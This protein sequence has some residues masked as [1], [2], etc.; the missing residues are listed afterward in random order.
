[1]Q[2][3][4]VD[5]RKISRNFEVNRNIILGLG[6]YNMFEE[7][8]N[9]FIKLEE[10]N[11][12]LSFE[13]YIAMIQI[14]TPKDEIKEIKEYLEDM[15]TKFQFRIS[16]YN[17]LLDIFLKNGKLELVGE[18][19]E[20]IQTHNV[21]FDQATYNYFLEYLMKTNATSEQRNSVLNEMKSKNFSINPEYLPSEPI[22]IEI[23]PKN[24]QPSSKVDKL[25]QQA[26]EFAT[27]ESNWEKADQILNEA[28][29]IS[30]KDFECLNLK[31]VAHV[32]M[33]KF[34]EAVEL[35]TK[36]LEVA[37]SERFVNLYS[38]RALAYNRL[39]QLDD[40][41]QDLTRLLQIDPT[42]HQSSYFRGSI[43]YYQKKYE[44]ALEDFTTAIL[45]GSRKSLVYS[46]RSNLLSSFI[47]L[48][49][50]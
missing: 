28:L 48:I 34:S 45:N 15:Q 40:A 3:I 26:L 47:I 9:Y 13:V 35:F 41:I 11:V 1:M 31:G 4:K 25:F 24:N 42:N 16:H 33:R 38:N 44:K 8:K 5:P 10:Y 6:K 46:S 21:E 50:F 14:L 2:S 20:A 18:L 27:I 39:N 22:S 12:P 19:F 36:A 17:S 30:P 7:A 29:K 32:F 43:Y 37:P 23:V 49:F